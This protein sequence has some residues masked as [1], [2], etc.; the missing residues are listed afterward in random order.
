MSQIL[1]PRQLYKFPAYIDV[2]YDPFKYLPSSVQ[3]V[4][5]TL[6]VIEGG[7]DDNIPVKL[8][9]AIQDV[10]RQ[11]FN[12]SCELDSYQEVHDC[13]VS[14]ADEFISVIDLDDG[15]LYYYH[16]EVHRHDEFNPNIGFDLLPRVLNFRHALTFKWKNTRDIKNAKYK[17]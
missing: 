7:E 6:D 16:L 3:R 15:R 12:V 2:P 8:S 10:L 9:D 17:F 5:P 13:D 1:N 11:E 14:N 4:P